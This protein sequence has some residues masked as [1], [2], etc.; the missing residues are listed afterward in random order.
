MARKKIERTTRPS[1]IEVSANGKYHYWR[2]TVSGLETFADEKRFGEV[3]AKFGTEEKLVSTFVLRPVQKYLDAD[4]SVERIKKLIEVNGGKL[5]HLGAETNKR[6]KELKKPR[7]KTLNQF[8]VDTVK[9]EEQ[10][11]TGE[12][13]EVKQKIY[14]W[15]D[16]PDYFKV[17][18]PT[19]I[20]I[21]AETKSSCM[22]PNIRLDDLCHGCKVFE[23]C[24]SSCKVLES[25]RSSAKHQ[26][27][28]VKVTPVNSWAV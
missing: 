9:V 12:V 15:T 5:P 3:V 24:Q 13:V 16:K 25:E 26:R 1:G 6:E 19:A 8:V 17:G 4:F 18:K 20:D 10:L 23:L 7:K 27:T 14:P 11:D 28:Q 2:C 22:F 21:G